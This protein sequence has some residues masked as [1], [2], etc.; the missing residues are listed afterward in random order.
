MSAKAIRISASACCWNR[1]HDRRRCGALLAARVIAPRAIRSSSAWYSCLG[2]LDRQL[3]P[4]R[5]HRPTQSDSLATGLAVGLQLSHA[6]RAAKA[7]HV[8]HVPLG[9]GLMSL[10]GAVSRMS[11]DR[12]G[13]LKVLAMDQAM[14][15]PFKVSTT[16]SNFMIGVTAAASAGV[17]LNRGYIAPGLTMPVVLGVLA[18]SM[19]GMR[20]PGH[21]PGAGAAHCLR[22]GGPGDRRRDDLQGHL[23]RT[24]TCHPLP[25]V[26]PT[27]RPTS[28]P[29]G[30][31]AASCK[32]ACSSRRWSYW[33][34]AFFIWRQNR[35]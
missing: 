35:L 27:R 19:L 30:L 24:L 31:W 32:S 13:S 7:Y 16:T 12:L 29:S 2:R 1:H 17:Y 18:G 22:P 25:N 4:V 33:P 9:F 34:A 14:I 5:S 3:A 20:H 15:L 8:V 11:G 21:R 10:A 26:G 23:R 28:E 6:E